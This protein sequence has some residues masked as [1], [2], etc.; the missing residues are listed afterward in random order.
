MSIGMP[1]MNSRLSDGHL[2]FIMG[3]HIAI[4]RCLHSEYPCCEHCAVCK[5]NSPIFFRIPLKLCLYH[6]WFPRTCPSLRCIVPECALYVW[7]RKIAV[8]KK[9]PLCCRANAQLANTLEFSVFFLIVFASELLPHDV[10]STCFQSL[11]D[12]DYW[13]PWW[14]HSMEILSVRV[15]GPLW[16]E[17]TGHRWFPPTKDG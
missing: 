13:R 15:T 12:A 6:A 10:N 16:G 1:I 5:E 9:K 3:I 8:L 7:I 17:S 4:G 2:R 14:R 11:D